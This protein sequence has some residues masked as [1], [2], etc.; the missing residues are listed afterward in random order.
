LRLYSKTAQLTAK[1]W[2]RIHRRST[3]LARL[4]SNAQLAGGPSE[5]PH[6][7]TLGFWRK[8]L[9]FSGPGYLVAVGYMDQAT[10][11]RPGGGS[12]FGYK[13]LCVILLSNL[14][15]ISPIVKCQAGI[16]TGRDLA[17]LAGITIPDRSHLFMVLCEIAICACDLAEVIGS[18]IALIF[19]S[20]YRSYGSMHHRAG[21]VAVMYLQN[22]G[23][24]YIEA[25]VVTLIVII[26]LAFW[27]R[28]FFQAK[29]RG[30]SRWIR[31]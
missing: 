16:A 23:F 24:R 19:Y 2:T 26:G 9:A 5:Y 13:L 6:S 17:R 11:R 20:K 14:M 12:A 10:G 22:K 31:S 3:S 15:A 7:K 8:L 4:E 28:L 29:L 21:L 27:P 1:Q 18:A 25:L 30:R